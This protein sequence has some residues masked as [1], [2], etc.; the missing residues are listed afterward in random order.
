MNSHKLHQSRKKK[1]Y[2]ERQKHVTERN[3][4][5][6]KS[7]IARRKKQSPQDPENILR[8]KRRKSSERIRRKAFRLALVEESK[9]KQ[10]AA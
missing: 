8:V 7:R 10:E 1:G 5:A 3:K 2:Y 6:V 4:A 9:R